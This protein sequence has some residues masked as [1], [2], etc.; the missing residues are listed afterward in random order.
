MSF[1]RSPTA[2]TDAAPVNSSPGTLDP[3]QP[4]NTLLVLNRALAARHGFD[5]VVTGPDMGVQKTENRLC[6]AIDSD[7]RMDEKGPRNPIDG[8][9][10][11]PTVGLS[12]SEIDFGGVLRD[13]NPPP[14]IAEITQ[15][16]NLLNHDDPPFKTRPQNRH[17]NRFSSK[18]C[19]RG[20]PGDEEGMANL[21]IKG[22]AFH[23]EWN[24]TISLRVPS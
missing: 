11:P 2:T 15:C 20:S 16:P 19:E 6:R 12:A 9:C 5:L 1:S 17:F 23:P 10:Q 4:A 7:Q 24:Y 3:S 21:N 22:D 18:M 8:R 13:D 14:R